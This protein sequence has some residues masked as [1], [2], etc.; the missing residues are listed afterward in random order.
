MR[1]K[2]GYAGER[3]PEKHKKIKKQGQY[4]HY[5]KEHLNENKKRGTR[6]TGGAE[7]SGDRAGRINGG[8]R[9]T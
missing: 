4:N 1:K 3:T 9:N 5:Q 7:K 6:L 8:E 2:Q